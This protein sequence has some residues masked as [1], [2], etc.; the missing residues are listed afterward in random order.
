MSKIFISY[1]RKNEP[2][3]RRLAA[4]LSDS[5]AEVWIDVADIPA[6]MKWSTAI[7]QGLDLCEVLIIII[8]PDSMASLNV[9]DEW[10]Y[11]LDQNK[12]VIP[13]LWEPT[14]IHF[15]LSR[16]QYINFH[17]RDYA[18]AFDQ[19][20]NELS[21]KGVHLQRNQPGSNPPE[22]PPPAAPSP[23]FEVHGA[24]A[25]FYRHFGAG[26][27]Q[28][29]LNS[30]AAIR[31]SGQAPRVFDVNGYEQKVRAEIDR[32]EL[33]SRREREYA[34]IRVMAQHESPETIYAALQVFWEAY[35]DYDPDAL[36]AQFQPPSGEYAV[37]LLDA[38]PKKINLIKVVRAQF[39]L[40]LVEAKNLVE[41]APAV[42]VSQIS[43]QQAHEIRS[44]M[45]AEGARVEVV[46]SGSASGQVAAAQSV[47]TTP[48]VPAASQRSYDVVLTDIGAKK[49]QV[50]KVVRALTGYGL[51]D[52]KNL[53]ESVP[54]FVLRNVDNRT[55]KHAQAQLQAE[56]ATVELRT[57]S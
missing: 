56:G 18:P 13:V 10:Q 17:K 23:V 8:S 51:N 28:A 36:A 44:A 25:E 29:A 54:Q 53:V 50:I 11:Y 37:M 42:I 6:G 5:G 14:K 7:Q 31:D 12:P 4:S 33:D 40:G 3:A 45:E 2:F 34:T 24:I 15:Q 55:A 19:L 57:V 52:A 21:A 46:K 26:D 32:I 39:S 38:G 9:E 22:P 48:P 35:P 49:I 47:S 16:I 20:L 30:L 1:S 43:E 27:W 41:S